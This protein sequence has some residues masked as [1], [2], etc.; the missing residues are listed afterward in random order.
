MI[1]PSI[2]P[3]KISVPPTRLSPLKAS[4][5]SGQVVAMAAGGENA[6]TLELQEAKENHRIS[7]PF[8]YNHTHHCQYNHTHLSNISPSHCHYNHTY[9][10]RPSCYHYNHT[11][12]LHT[13]A[14]PINTT[15]TPTLNFHSTGLVLQPWLHPQP[16]QKTHCQ[17]MP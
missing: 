5:T 12:C 15:A 11:H 7:L 17:K 1:V 6:H 3:K 2:P 16:R 10:L 13:S 14:P 9:C 4:K 8:Y